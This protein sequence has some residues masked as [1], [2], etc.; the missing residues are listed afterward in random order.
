MSWTSGGCPPISPIRKRVRARFK[1]IRDSI[2]SVNRQIRARRDGG[3]WT[4]AQP[5]GRCNDDLEYDRAPGQL[6]SGGS[7]RSP[8]CLS[9]CCAALTVPCHRSTPSRLLSVAIG[10]RS[11]VR[12]VQNGRPGPATA[13]GGAKCAG[14]RS[15]SERRGAAKICNA[16]RLLQQHINGSVVLEVNDKAPT[17]GSTGLP[18]RSRVPPSAASRSIRPVRSGRSGCAGTPR[19]AD[20]GRTG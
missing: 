18:S 14:N 19:R 10:T 11:R 9:G 3:T 6:E 8:M 20:F 1:T 7:R 2:R 4:K 12:E 5:A 15:T 13:A 17:G 16:G